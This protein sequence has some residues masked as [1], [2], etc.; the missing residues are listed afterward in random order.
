M[1]VFVHNISH[2]IKDALTDM[3]HTD[4]PG[5][6]DNDLFFLPL[7]H[8]FSFATNQNKPSNSSLRACN[9]NYSTDRCLINLFKIKQTC[10]MSMFIFKK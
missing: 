5:L 10:R 3:D 1:E 8:P 2:V 4:G 6:N 7:C 9:H